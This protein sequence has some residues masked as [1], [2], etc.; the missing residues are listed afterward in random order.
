MVV[1]AIIADTAQI[2]S[3]LPEERGHAAQPRAGL[4]VEMRRERFVNT[5]V[6]GVELRELAVAQ[7][8][9]VD[10]IAVE[11]CE[12]QRLER[13]E[14][15][16]G[17]G[18]R[19]AHEQKIFQPH[20]EFPRK[21]QPRLVRKDHARLQRGVPR[22][23]G[24]AP[25][26]ALRSLVDAEQI[27]DAVAGAV[28][29]VQSLVPEW[30]AGENVKVLPRHA[31]AEAR[32]G[33][34][35]VSAQDERAGALL[36]LGDRAKCDG[37]R[38]VGRAGAV[39]TAGVGEE[40]AVRFER[41]VG[42]LRRLVMDDGAVGAI[43]ENG[44]EARLKIVRAFAAVFLQFRGGGK[45]G[46]SLP[47]G[48]TLEP[49][50]KA[51]ERDAVGK[52][53]AAEILLLHGILDRFHG[54]NGTGTV[55]RLRAVRHALRQAIVR[56][57]AVEQHA[58]AARQSADKAVDAFIV[59]KA[60]AVGG[61]RRFH[62]L[63]DRARAGAEHGI[64]LRQQQKAEKHRRAGHVV[65]AQIQQ[66]R[67]LVECR[68][69]EGVR[70][71][72]RHRRAHARELVR[73]RFARVVDPQLPHRRGGERRAVGPERV[74][75]V[76]VPRKADM[77]CAQLIPEPPRKRGVDRAGIEAEQAPVLQLREQEALECR[78]VRLAGAHQLD[79]AAGQL[80]LR[81][82]KVAP[83]R[84]EESAAR[85]NE[86]RPRAAGEAGEVF[87]RLEVVADILRGVKIIGRDKVGGK[88]ALRHRAAQRR[89]LFCGGHH[90]FL[91]LCCHYCSVFI[92]YRSAG[93]VKPSLDKRWGSVYNIF[94]YNVL[95][96]AAVG[97]EGRRRAAH[98]KETT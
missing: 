11:G 32:G 89:E 35:E 36:L 50:E 98:R 86:Q 59:R 1:C 58:R 41:H 12:R 30:A 68:D 79:A 13:K 2:A 57:R 72:V 67:K 29:V 55:E 92:V 21:I 45:L 78:D 43:G 31:R 47:H 23:G 63:A 20:A 16:V 88:S 66:P 27:A 83:V 53:R 7:E 5:R 46:G 61:E 37:T 33:E 19:L 80:A 97:P 25:M 18:L 77:L 87:A 54:H 28:V 38:Y 82:Q 39:V 6:V 34:S 96:C 69:N 64:L 10:G 8:R 22:V 60:H 65:P 95:V 17:V 40:Q 15:S 74:D 76:F 44:V 94:T 51:C 81:L 62:F 9:R 3:S 48:V 49:A 42:L 56:R 52:V 90:G 14:A 26:D 93:F 91:L 24:D 71:L 73:A 85:Q 4:R 84:P 75:K 70:S